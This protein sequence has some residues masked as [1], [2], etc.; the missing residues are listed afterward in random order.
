MKQFTL[1][2]LLFTSICGSAAAQDA[3]FYRIDRATENIEAKTPDSLAY[4]LTAPYS[5]DLQKVRSIFRWVADHVAYDI[6]R[7]NRPAT[8]T[9]YKTVYDTTYESRALNERVA[10]SVLKK[11]K[12]V[13]YGFTRLFQALCD[14][15]GIRCAIVSG[16]ARSEG[17]HTTS[18]FIANHNWN[19]VYI[20]SAWHLVDVTWASG[21]ITMPSNEFVQSFDESYFFARP[22]QFI[23]N[24]Y[25]E[26]LAWTLLANPP[27]LKEFDHSPFKPMA[28]LKYGI[29]TYYPAGGVID[30]AVG[31]TIRVELALSSKLPKA[32]AASSP[33]D[34][35]PPF[36]PASWVYLKP[37][38]HRPGKPLVYTYIVPPTAA[39]WLNIV[40]NEDVVLR[41]RIRRK[42]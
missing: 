22:E 30:A 6:Q 20:D 13:C 12:A 5:T 29:A 7:F 25:P 18:S 4:Y 14:Y 23:R 19:A 11:R 3:S 16:Y 10:Y 33:D 27:A 9:R 21:Y 31:D 36:Q 39:D 26:D 42:G 24:H 41:Y 38:G 8:T 2:F 17:D 34:D 40:Y 35:R 1:I 15:A 32:I 37:E 28:F